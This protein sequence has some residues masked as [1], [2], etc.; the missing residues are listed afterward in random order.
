MKSYISKINPRISL[1]YL[2][3]GKENQHFDRKSA[4]IDTRKIA[5]HISAFANASG[6]V[7]VIGIEDEGKLTGF[8]EIGLS[9]LHKFKTIPFDFLKSSP[10]VK[11]EVIHIKGN[12]SKDIILLIY[13]I[14]ASGKKIIRT[15]S[16]DVYLRVGDQSRKLTEDEIR[17]LEYKKRLKISK[18]TN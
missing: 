9:K 17:E 10:V 8:N 15:V 5:N 3:T 11:T 14:K 13:H 18:K 6:G 16:D 12:K 4:R 2:T 1:Q 7:L